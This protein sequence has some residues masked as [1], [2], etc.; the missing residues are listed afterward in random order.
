MQN[1]FVFSLF[2]SHQ[3]LVFNVRTDLKFTWDSFLLRPQHLLFTIWCLQGDVPLPN[4]SWEAVLCLWRLTFLKVPSLPHLGQKRFEEGSHVFS[5]V[6]FQKRFQV[7][8]LLNSWGSEPS[9]LHLHFGSILPLRV[10][11][12]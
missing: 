6:I 10:P 3:N 9:N 4:S 12:T 2:P 11:H 7:I 5:T 8:H 1:K